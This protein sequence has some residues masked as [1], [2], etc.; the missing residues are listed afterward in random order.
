[1][2]C[3]DNPS[4]TKTVMH[5]VVLKQPGNRS[6]RPI[7]AVDN[8]LPIVKFQLIKIFSCV[9]FCANLHTQQGK[10]KAIYQTKEAIIFKKENKKTRTGSIK[11]T[12][13][14]KKWP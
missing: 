3:E 11:T 12:K 4:F 13:P 10:Q 1:M 9:Q 14:Y 6:T 2:Y 5:I 7:M 8:I